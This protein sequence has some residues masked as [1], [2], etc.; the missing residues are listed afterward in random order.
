MRSPSEFEFAALL[1]YS[2]HGTSTI[3]QQ[4]RDVRDRV[5]AG[6]P[7]LLARALDRIEEAREEWFGSFIGER[8]LLVPAP[9]SAPVKGNELWPAKRICEAL[10]ERGL[11]LGMETRLGRSEPVPKAAYSAPDQRPSVKRHVETLHVD[12]QLIGAPS[13]TIVDDFITKGRMLFAACTVVQRACATSAVRGFALVRTRNL[14]PDLERI[15]DPCV[16]RIRWNAALADVE[17]DP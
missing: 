9:R 16:G 11:A 5:K 6:D 13:I 2:K 14:V 8:T 1:A 17:R 4:S 15:V 7:R 10:V 12:S 3:A